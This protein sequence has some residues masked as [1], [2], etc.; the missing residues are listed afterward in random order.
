MRS[1]DIRESKLHSALR[2]GWQDSPNKDFSR[3][4]KSNG[5][6]FNLGRN[7]QKR[8]PNTLIAKPIFPYLANVSSKQ[9]LS[10]N[11]YLNW[12]LQAVVRKSENLRNIRP[13]DAVRNLEAALFM[14]GYS[15]NPE[16]DKNYWHFVDKP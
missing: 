14:I 8:N 5:S 16:F 4:A 12:I 13:H 7:K 15:V 11:M 3:P 6:R 10:M 9:R 1:A 2:F